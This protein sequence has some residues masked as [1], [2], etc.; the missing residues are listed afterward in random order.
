MQ[1]FI[2]MVNLEFVAQSWGIGNTAISFYLEILRI[3][4]ILSAINVGMSQ[5]EMMNNGFD[6]FIRGVKYESMLSLQKA[7]ITKDKL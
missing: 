4:I 7:T 1:N 6:A 5:R 3:V 2:L